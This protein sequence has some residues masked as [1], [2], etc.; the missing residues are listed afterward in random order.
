MRVDSYSFGKIV[1]EGKAYG[2]DVIIF[3]DRVFSPWWRKEGHLLH[4]EDLDE[5]IKERPDTLII[6]TGYMGVM[7]TPQAL[8][9][10]LEK[11]GINV[12]VERSTK[13]VENYNK[14][15]KKGVVAAIHLTC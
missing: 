1:I 13:A 12:I 4:M 7:K 11:L 2:K 6:G 9:K 3:E 8:I 15:A 10:E 5:V 14:N